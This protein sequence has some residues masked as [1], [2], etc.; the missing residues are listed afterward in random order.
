[1]KSG[2]GKLENE[3]SL[4]DGLD[5]TR[6]FFC[7]FR[8]PLDSL[9]SRVSG[10][11]NLTCLGLLLLQRNPTTIFCEHKSLGEKYLEIQTFWIILVLIIR[12]SSFGKILFYVTHE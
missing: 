7:S 2:A 6:C 4:K 9:V 3:S 5:S 8:K 10:H 12:E 1:M 11:H